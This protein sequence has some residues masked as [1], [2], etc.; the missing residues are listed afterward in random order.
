LP[1]NVVIPAGSATATVTVTPIADGVTE[2]AET[3]VMT[4]KA[5]AAYTVGTPSSA[6]VTITDGGT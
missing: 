3:V 2:G 4:L 5:G 1:L 6:T